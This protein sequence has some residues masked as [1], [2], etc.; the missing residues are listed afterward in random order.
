MPRVPLEQGSKEWLAYRQCHIMATAASC[1]MGTNPFMSALELWEEMLGL[2]LPITL[3]EAMKRGIKLEPEARELACKLIGIDFEPCVYESDKYSWQAASLDGLSACGKYILEIKCPGI[4]SHEMA[5]NNIIRGY[6]TTQ[7]QHQSCV[8]PFPEKVFYFS[9]FPEHNEKYKI[10]EV[11]PDYEYIEHMIQ[12]QK[13][14]WIKLCTLQPPEKPWTLKKTSKKE[15][16]E[17][18]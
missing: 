9:Y 15:L 2:R 4:K 16:Q 18:I 1:I 8:L 7:M 17:I 13:E 14:F 6:Y 11:N 10:I 12:T 3:N 5:L